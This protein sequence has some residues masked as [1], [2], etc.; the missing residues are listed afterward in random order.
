MR[1]LP[2]GRA[3]LLQF[4]RTHLAIWQLDPAGVGLTSLQVAA[5][6]VLL[7][8]SE[9]AHFAAHTQRIA[10]E[11]ATLS[12][13]I[14]L[15]ELRDSTAR[16]LGAIKVFAREQNAAGPDVNLVYPAA[17]I[18]VP[19]RPAPLP[20]PAYVRA[21]NTVITMRGEPTLSWKPPHPQ[22]AR[23]RAA[24]SSG[25]IYTVQRKHAGERGFSIVYV[26]KPATF[27]DAALP[28]GETQYFVRATRGDKH[29]AWTQAGTI[30]IGGAGAAMVSGESL[31][32]AA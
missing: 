2:S 13:N 10:A 19:L 26:G 16:A 24:G 27:T 3:D 22:D 8:E 25:L 21:V 5:M 6:A 29:G 18:D 20:R 14:K 28:P 1:I 11:S 4:V 9:Q 7:A 15:G 23:E 32:L 30:S 17:G 31:A 12:S